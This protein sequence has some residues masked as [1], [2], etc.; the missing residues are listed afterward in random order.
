MKETAKGR[1]FYL[2]FTKIAILERC[3]T[4]T[5]RKKQPNTLEAM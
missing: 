2:R 1:G 3:I 4:F 5:L